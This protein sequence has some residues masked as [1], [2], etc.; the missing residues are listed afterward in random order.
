MKDNNSL[1]INHTTNM[2]LEEAASLMEEAAERMSGDDAEHLFEMGERYENISGD[3]HDF[4]KAFECY[5]KSANMGYSDAETKVGFYYIKGRG[6]VQKNDEEAMRWLQLAADKGNTK[7]MAF[8][9]DVYNPSSTGFDTSYGKNWNKAFE[10]YSKAAEL[11]GYNGMM[12]LALAY[13]HGGNGVEKDIEKA[14]MYYEKVAEMD[15]RLSKLACRY[16]AEIYEQIG[17]KRKSDALYEKAAKL[18]DEKSLSIISE[19][20]KNQATEV[21]QVQTLT[22]GEN[23]ITAA[24]KDAFMMGIEDFEFDANH[25]IIL[26]G[27]VYEGAMECGD[28]ID[29]ILWNGSRIRSKVKSIH[30]HGFSVDYAMKGEKV[31]L[32]IGSVKKEI[33][34]EVAVVHPDKGLFDKK[35]TCALHVNSVH[36]G[37]K[38]EPIYNLYTPIFKFIFPDGKECM[39][40]RCRGTMTLGQGRTS[41]NPGEDAVVSVEL[42]DAAFLHPDMKIEIVEKP[43]ENAAVIAHGKIN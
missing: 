1:N 2:S 12:Q 39:D 32:N 25:N 28:D 30:E 9:G 37:G 27:S 17:L 3:T 33:I 14:I 6:A 26:K 42:K 23:K 43:D 21:T 18:G 19:R 35:F 29:I 36:E 38:N 22:S 31:H 20:N 41:I 13:K 4:V 40:C 10:Y 34:G 7:A 8:I 16:L 15:C 11:G 24:E 5:M